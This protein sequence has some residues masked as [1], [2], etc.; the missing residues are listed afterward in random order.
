MT[1]YHKTLADRWHTFH[2]AEQMANIGAEVGRTINWRNKGNH[3]MALQAFY[4]ALELIDFTVADDKNRKRLGEILRIR[5][6]FADYIVG[7]N[8]YHSSAKQWNDYF[9]QFGL[10]AAKIRNV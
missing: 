2:F 7:D 8:I 1:T 10:Y 4:R 5:E 6:V 3:E 9:H